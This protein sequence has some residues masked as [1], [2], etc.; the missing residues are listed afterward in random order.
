MSGAQTEGF[1]VTSTI[2]GAHPQHEAYPLLPGDLLVRELDGTW[3]KE[4][5][6]LAVGGFVLTAEQEAGLQRILFARAGLAYA[7]VDVSA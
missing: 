3:M 6:G 2:E 7:V 5:P 4:A 1:R